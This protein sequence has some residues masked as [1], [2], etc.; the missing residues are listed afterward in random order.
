MKDYPEK[1]VV[2]ASEDVDEIYDIRLTPTFYIIG[3]D[4]KIQYKN[5]PLDR[6][7]SILKAIE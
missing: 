4:H 1:W 6:V 7:V 2:G 3:P 5:L